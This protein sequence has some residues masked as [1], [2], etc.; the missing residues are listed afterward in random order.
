MIRKINKINNLGRFENFEGTSEFGKNTI[1]FGFNGAGKSTLSDIFYS[2]TKDDT[3]EYLTRRRTLN[4]EDESGEKNITIELTGENGELYRFENDKWTSKPEKIYVFNEKYV[5][6]HVFVSSQVEGDTAPIG[7]GTE[8]AG[9]M[10][11]KSLLVHSNQELYREINEEIS[12][13]LEANIKIKDFTHPKINARTNIL[14]RFEKIVG[15]NLYALADK[16]KIKEKLHNNERYSREIQIIENCREKYNRIKNVEKIS[17]RLVLK[18]MKYIPRVSS[19]QIAEFLEKTLTTTDIKWAVRGYKNQKNKSVC[20]MC[21]Q[22]IS[23]KQAIA[24]FDKLG[25]YVS[26][27]KDDNLNEYSKELNVIATKLESLNIGEKIDIFV[28]IVN[29]LNDNNLLLKRETDRLQKGL[30]WT[31]EKTEIINNLVKKIYEKAENPYM[32]ISFLN[33]EDDAIKLLN[34]V[35]NNIITLGDIIDC[36]QER[37]ETKNQKTINREETG[38]IYELSY[39]AA[40]VY[41]GIA[42][43]IKSKASK[44]IKNNNKINALN[45]EINDC[46]NQSRLIQ[47]NDFLLNLN[48]HLKIEVRDNQYYIKLKDFK[49]KKHEDKETI[50]SEGENRAIAFAYFL[51]EVSNDENANDERIIVVDDPISSMDL[52]RKS[53]ISH[54]ISEM[55]NDDNC[56]MILMTHD[57]GFVERVK[58]YLSR[59]TTCELLEIRSGRKDFI[60]LSI[61]DYLTDDEK[62][63]KTF[64]NQAENNDNE[65]DK[66]IAFMSLRPFAYVMKVT[67][68][69][70]EKVMKKSTYF[71][72]TLYSKNTRISFKKKDYDNKGLKSYVRL[73]SIAT[74]SKFNVNEIVGDFSFEGFDFEKISDLYLSVPLDSMENMRKKVLLLRPLIEA[75]FFQ[76]SQKHKF[77]PEKISKMYND[78]IKANKTD[79]EKMKMCLQLKEMYDASKKYHHGAEDGSLLGISWVNPNEVEYFDQIIQE[80]IEKI[81]SIGELRSLS[82]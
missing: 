1:L 42:E 4:R 8:G 31:L 2:L 76:F 63:Y 51:A 79:D 60:G 54:K 17:V 55:M 58:S 71:A 80:I 3:E 14:K 34:A 45:V 74:G 9:P 75:C 20:P 5:E 73:V 35:I 11:K 48:T 68:E 22:S 81:R 43:S 50:T 46:Y 40:G 6:D 7:I 32:D 70:F 24:F 69:K 39:G 61:E 72:H 59:K 27:N 52:S 78:T 82:A 36:I 77:D 33:E 44:Y 12:Q 21:G 19:K 25:K 10:R 64:I 53:I 56:Q 47:V 67:N 38:K 41:R 28:E 13:L 26:Q 23:D 65:L 16:E 66:I 57:I 49:A 62:V 15:F 18:K 29:E 30:A 37:S